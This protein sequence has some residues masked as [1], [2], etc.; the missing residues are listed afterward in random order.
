MSYRPDSE[1][2]PAFS[3]AAQALDAQLDR[4]RARLASEGV[5]IDDRSNRTGFDK[6]GVPYFLW[7]WRFERRRPCGAEIASASVELSYLE[8]PKDSGTREIRERWVGE[9]F[10]P[11]FQPAQVTRIRH[12]GQS[13]L[14]Y[15]NVV[16][17][18]MASLVVQAIERAEHELPK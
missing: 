5:T 6:S 4:A 17:G 12:E 14:S 10:Q 9:V 8:P 7:S 11:V 3:H 1:L 13:S 15:E 18:D 16:T 2:K